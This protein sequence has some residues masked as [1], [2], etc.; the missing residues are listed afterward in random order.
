MMSFDCDIQFMVKQGPNWYNLTRTYRAKRKAVSFASL[1][2][3]YEV[4][5]SSLCGKLTGKRKSIV[6][7]LLFSETGFHRSK[8]LMHTLTRIADICIN[9]I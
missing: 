4:E 9:I 3:I 6:K 8:T 5:T 1:V 2:E 7:R